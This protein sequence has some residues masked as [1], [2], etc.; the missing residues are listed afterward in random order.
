VRGADQ[1]HVSSGSNLI[2]NPRLRDIL[3]PRTGSDIDFEAGKNLLP[4]LEELDKR[5]EGVQGALVKGVLYEH[6]QV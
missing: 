1:R 6:K 2:R 3:S 5:L 4:E